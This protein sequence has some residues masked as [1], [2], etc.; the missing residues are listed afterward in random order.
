MTSA[1][2][3]SGKTSMGVTA[4]RNAE[5]PAIVLPQNMKN[6]ENKNTASEVLTLITV[7]SPYK[8][9]GQYT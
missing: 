1:R 8:L 5:S 2:S 3:L 4:C 9:G 7:G 6:T